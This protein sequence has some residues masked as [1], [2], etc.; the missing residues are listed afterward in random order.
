MKH[1]IVAALAIAFV[2]LALTGCAKLQ[3]VMTGA[4]EVEARAHAFYVTYVAPFRPAAA[5]EQEQ[6]LYAKV[7]NLCA[8]NAP[9]AS[10]QKAA[11]AASSAR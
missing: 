9:E 8:A 5:V 11:D 10:I 2:A 1:R 7:M 4:C 6:R 3:K